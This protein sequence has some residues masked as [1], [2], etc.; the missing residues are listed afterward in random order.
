[1]IA[2]AWLLLTLLI[3]QPA[4]ADALARSAQAALEQGDFSGAQNAYETL[5]GMGLRSSGLYYNL[6]LAYEGLGDSGRALL[7]YRRAYTLMPRDGVIIAALNRIRGQRAD[8]LGED[9]AFIDALATF[10]GVVTVGELLLL[11]AVVWAGWFACL[12]LMRI[13]PRHSDWLLLLALLSAGLM[14]GG[15]LLFSRLYVEAV[16]PAAVVI[17]PQVRVMSGPGDAYLPIYE[18]HAAAELRVLEFNGGW[19]RF[20]LPDGRQGWIPETMIEGV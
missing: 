4:D 12:V 9:E 19:V 3:A 17:T 18:L 5:L 7:N 2:W 10:S 11:L 8:R 13:R 14:I 20:I 1:M 15:G 6:G 16:R